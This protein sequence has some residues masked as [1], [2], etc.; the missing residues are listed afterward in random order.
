LLSK[1]PERRANERMKTHY[2]TFIVVVLLPVFALGY[3][4]DDGNRAPAQGWVFDIKIIN[5][6]QCPYAKEIMGMDYVDGENA[7]TF[8][9]N[10]DDALYTCNADNGNYI[11]AL[12]L[13]YG[14]NPHPFGV[15]YDGGGYPHVNDFSGRKIHWTD[16]SNWRYYSNPAGNQG[17]GMD[18]DGE[19]IWEAYWTEGVFRFLPDGTREEYYTASEIEYQMSGMT[20]FPFNDN[21][22]LM[23]ATHGDYVFYFY[24]YDGGSITLIATVDCPL[25]PSQS[26]GLAYAAERGSVFW[27]YTLGEEEWIAELDLGIE[28]DGGGGGGGDTGI[29]PTSMGAIKAAYR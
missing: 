9:S 2:L 19:C 26:Y 17:S 21:I 27:S 25:T 20:V 14:G 12:T 4:V 6:F 28:D 8:A 1:N 16:F 22:W 18:Y 10:L 3:A 15:C 24:E 7:I 11:R 23:F 13:N 5:T 29:V